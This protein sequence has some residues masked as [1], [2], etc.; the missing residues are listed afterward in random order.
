M[1]V[2]DVKCLGRHSGDGESNAIYQG[3]GNRVLILYSPQWGLLRLLWWR[4]GRLRRKWEG[5]EE[6]TPWLPM[7]PLCQL[8]SWEQD[9][10]L[11][12]LVSHESTLRMT[13]TCFY[14]LYL[15]N[16][17]FNF[18]FFSSVIDSQHWGRFSSYFLFFFPLTRPSWFR[19]SD[20]TQF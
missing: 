8:T 15:N 11:P 1:K 14:K 6:N 5:S 13:A 10:G 19:M 7:E 3:V 12:Y 18:F 4:R 17:L 9:P 2:Q 16:I 20:S